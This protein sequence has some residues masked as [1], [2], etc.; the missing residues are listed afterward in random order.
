M[1]LKG[2][3][4]VDAGSDGVTFEVTVRNGGDEPE[5]LTFPSGKRV[6]VAVFADGKS[7]WRWSDGRMFTQAVETATLAPGESFTES[8]TWAEPSAGEYEAR[9]TLAA[10]DAAVKA[11]EPFT[12]SA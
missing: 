2:R 9:A 5:E 4:A 12:V 3:L 1:T 6:D 8:L 7:V 11:V 10:R